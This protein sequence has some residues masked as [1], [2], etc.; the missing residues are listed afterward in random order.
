MGI[1]IDSSPS[2]KAFKE[3][4]GISF[5]LLSD[6]HRKVAKL[7]NVLIDNQNIAARATYI[8]DKSGVIRYQLIHDLGLQRSEQELLRVCR[9]LTKS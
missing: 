4:L 9:E 7:Y 1:S 3:K 8:I 5:P 6:M 2:H